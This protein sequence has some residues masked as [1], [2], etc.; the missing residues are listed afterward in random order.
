M[1]LQ[2][3]DISSR[4]LTVYRTV[5]YTH[6]YEYAS[7]RRHSPHI[8]A[9]AKDMYVALTAIVLKYSK[10]SLPKAQKKTLAAIRCTPN[11]TRSSKPMSTLPL[12]VYLTQLDR[13]KIKTRMHNYQP[14]ILD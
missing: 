13:Y 9:S 2:R 3:K 11:M 6:A 4:G 8:L 12:E 10:H 5:P 1:Y 14:I 7:M